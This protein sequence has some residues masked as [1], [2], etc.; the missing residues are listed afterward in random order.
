[1]TKAPWVLS[2]SEANAK[3]SNRGLTASIAGI[4]SGKFLKASVKGIDLSIICSSE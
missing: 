3:D 4:W 2:P 1:M